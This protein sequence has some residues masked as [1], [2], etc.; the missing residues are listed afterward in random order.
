MEAIQAATERIKAIQ[1]SEGIKLAKVKERTLED[2]FAFDVFEWSTEAG[3]EPKYE[4]LKAVKS[5][6]ATAVDIAARTRD[7]WYAIVYSGYLKIDK[8]GPYTFYLAS[9]DGSEL[10]IS[11]TPVVSNLGMHG[12]VELSQQVDLEEG[13]YAV[14]ITFYQG[15]GGH[16]LTFSWT[17]PGAEEKVLVPAEVLKHLPD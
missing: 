16:N 9:D 3:A 1:L 2:G 17:T 15:S 11:D 12:V 13:F 7:E 8:G 4:E 6:V 10:F 5:G 14:K